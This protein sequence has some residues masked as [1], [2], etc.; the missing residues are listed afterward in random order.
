MQNFRQYEYPFWEKSNPAQRG[1]RREKKTPSVLIGSSWIFFFWV[2]IVKMEELGWGQNSSL[3]FCDS[4]S[5]QTSWGPDY[6][7]LFLKFPLGVLALGSVHARPSAR[8]PIDMSGF[9]VCLLESFYFYEFGVLAKFRNH[10]TIFENNPMS[11]KIGHSVGVGGVPG[12]FV[13]DR[14]PNTFVS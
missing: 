3:G 5:S 9:F 11:P 4:N 7:L 10:T 2:Q 6:L 8:T 14:N 1:E 13:V 12:F